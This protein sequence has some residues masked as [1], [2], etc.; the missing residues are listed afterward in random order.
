MAAVGVAY[1]Q[2]F[3]FFAR[4][5]SLEIASLDKYFG[6]LYNPFA[7]F[8]TDLA[9]WQEQMVLDLVRKMRFILC[10]ELSDTEKPE[11]N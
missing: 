5:K 8:N 3:W 10:Q 1:A 11:A 6:V 4:R 7:F 9:D 2:G